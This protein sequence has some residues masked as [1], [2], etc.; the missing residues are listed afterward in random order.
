MSA[1]A[2][3]VRLADA[4][5]AEAVAR[6]MVSFRNHL[7]YDWPSDNAFLAGVEKLLDERDSD[8]LLG[9]V[10]ADS[11]PAGVVALRYRFGIWRAGVDCLVEDVYVEERARGA[12][13]GKALMAFALERARERGARRM[14]LDTN[15]TN[16][17]AIALYESLGFTSQSTAYDGRD[18]YFRLHLDAGP[19]A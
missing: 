7:G 4:H 14:E 6:L 8:F 3:I 5:D 15:E 17:A 2:P 12:G 1:V 16:A 19:D 11:G 18:L 10:D 13:L 9:F